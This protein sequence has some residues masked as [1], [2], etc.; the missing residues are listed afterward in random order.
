LKEANIN[1]PRSFKD[2]VWSY[3]PKVDLGQIC[4]FVLLRKEHDIDLVGHYK[5]QKAYA[6]H[7]SDFVD[8]IYYTSL[9][10]TKG[11]PSRVS[12][13]QSIRNEAHDVGIALNNKDSLIS[14]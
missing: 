5:S 11:M 8:I 4:S 1:D 12:S 10:G 13:A 6:Y 14:N 9:N 2:E 3:W 7:Q